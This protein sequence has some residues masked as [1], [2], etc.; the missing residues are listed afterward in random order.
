MSQLDSKPWFKQFW[1]W[2]FITLPLI[3]IIV[4]V[5][6][7]TMAVNTEDS[8]VVD[9]Y[10]KKGKGIN[11]ELSR[12]ETAAELGIAANLVF[13]IDTVM[14]SFVDYNAVDKSALTLHLR[15]TTLSKLDQSVTLVADA[16]GNYRGRLPKPVTGRWDLTLEPFDKR[17]KL[18]QKVRLF[19]DSELILTP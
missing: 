10:Y 11:R 19:P 13:D 5:A 16:S 15:H 12:I 4:N 17:W 1:P 18:Q 7:I 8:L 9:D 6:M 3:S 2:F 14:M